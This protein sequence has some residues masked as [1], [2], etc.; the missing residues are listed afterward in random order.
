[1]AKTTASES[2]LIRAK[3]A[4]TPEALADELTR[5][6]EARAKA[7]KLPPVKAGIA[8]GKAKGAARAGEPR[9]PGR[10]LVE[11]ERK[12]YPDLT[13]GRFEGEPRLVWIAPDLFRHEPN[14]DK[15]FRFVRHDGEIIQPG[16]MRT[17]GGSIPRPLW[18]V[19]DLSPWAYAPAFL[20]HD[21]LF[22]LHHCG[23]TD[24]G[25]EEVRDIMLEGV[26]T[27]METGVCEASRLKFDL[28]YA[29]IDSFVARQ[30][31]E[32]PGCGLE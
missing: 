32:K 5:Q 7:R 9:E 4:L 22:D 27:L 14:P 11:A 19:R 3:F 15:P 16:E 24:K 2:K 21:W 8:K 23:R 26:R 12:Y 29:G 17:D 20:I 13:P 1:M 18:F 25:F 28:I 10:P 30:V 31:W 6:D